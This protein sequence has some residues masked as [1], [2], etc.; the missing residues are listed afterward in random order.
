MQG[1]ILMK[2]NKFLIM[3]IIC[4]PII[5]MEKNIQS[6]PA[7]HMEMVINRINKGI[8]PKKLLNLI[9]R[10][11][12]GNLALKAYAL[13]K[14]WQRAASYDYFSLKTAASFEEIFN[15]AQQCNDHL[16]MEVVKIMEKYPG[17]CTSP[18][19]LAIEFNAEKG[20]RF[21]IQMGESLT[22]D[23]LN[24]AILKEKSHFLKLLL[25]AGCPVQNDSFFHPTYMQDLPLVV[26]LKKCD[27]DAAQI[28]LPATNLSK[29]IPYA[30]GKDSLTIAEYLAL[31][32][33][34][35]TPE[36]EEMRHNALFYDEKIPKPDY[37][38][39]R[40]LLE[41]LTTKKTIQ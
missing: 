15:E 26:A 13:G 18:V 10:K 17:Y 11:C 21:L 4:I 20:L 8:G 16:A 12:D 30:W 7:N 23:N 25:Q 29:K 1:V 38:K 24:H 34:Y 22:I 5:S 6:I 9:N 41:K 36:Y 14:T 39:A 27:E 33:P 19:D 40:A 3:L 32:Y 31:E 37:S 28:L 2:H 35:D